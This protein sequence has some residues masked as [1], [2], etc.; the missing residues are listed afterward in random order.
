MTPMFC[1]HCRRT[2]PVY[3]A[4]HMTQPNGSV[5]LVGSCPV[6][7]KELFVSVSAATDPASL[8]EPGRACRPR[9]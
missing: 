2:R 1:V 4:Q 7:A 6:C 9:R 8:P 5:I 3:R